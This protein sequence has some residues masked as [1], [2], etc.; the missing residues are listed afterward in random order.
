VDTTNPV[1]TLVYPVNDTEYN[2]TSNGTKA[3]TFTYKVTD[4]LNAKLR[5]CSLYIGGSMEDNETSVSNG[6]S[7]TLHYTFENDDT[8]SWYVN[9]SD[10]SGHYNASSPR[11][12]TI[13]PYPDSGD[14]DEDG[15]GGGS[16]EDNC[17][18]NEKR[19]S[20]GN[21]EQCLNDEWKVIT[22]CSYG[23]NSTNFTCKPLSESSYSG[24]NLTYLK[25]KTFDYLEIN[26]TIDFILDNSTH[27]IFIKNI[28]NSS[29][30]LQINSTVITTT[31]ALNETKAF[32]LNGNGYNDLSITVK[33]IAD[34]TVTLLLEAIEEPAGASLGSS[35]KPLLSFNVD[36]FTK[37]LVKWKWYI[38]IFLGVVVAVFVVIM[39][40]MK[41][42][43]SGKF[44]Y[45]KINNKSVKI[46]K[47]GDGGI[48]IE[49]K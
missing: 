46:K 14:G 9:C 3:V 12:I 5:N 8:Y 15:G 1:V 7:E 18:P 48:R 33:T 28:T 22:N 31:L 20:A 6:S 45:V 2:L 19:C 41:K 49:K 43:K 36:A 44:A 24:N 16:T 11:T 10:Y 25:N 38:L 27:T 35:K 13:N 42:K 30:T 17:P 34:D 39:L 37:T 32:D 29:V 23:C 21:V 26:E 40:V 47:R 4:N